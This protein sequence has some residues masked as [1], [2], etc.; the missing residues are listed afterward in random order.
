[1]FSNTNTKRMPR[2]QIHIQI[3]TRFEKQHL[4]ILFINN[5]QL[6]NHVNSKVLVRSLV[7]NVTFIYIYFND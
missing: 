6:Q 3:F 7:K 2:I 4:P 1:M 5:I